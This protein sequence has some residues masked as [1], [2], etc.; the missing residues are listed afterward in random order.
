[1][2]PNFRDL[3]HKTRKAPGE[4]TRG[5]GR[6][7]GISALPLVA[8][9]EPL[10]G[11]LAAVACVP[12]GYCLPFARS[13]NRVD[14]FPGVGASGIAVSSQPATMID[15]AEAQQRRSHKSHST[16]R[17][18]S[19]DPERPPNHRPATA[20]KEPGTQGSM[21]LRL[22]LELATRSP[23]PLDRKKAS[24][25]HRQPAYAKPGGRTSPHYCVGSL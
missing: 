14:F 23:E 3:Y 9:A 15:E 20:I 18:N 11:N 1:M 13:P 7:V 2:F 6:L 22:C 19:Q 17:E 24:L 4:G 5:P 8:G 25:W 21:T 12:C 16:S 10:P